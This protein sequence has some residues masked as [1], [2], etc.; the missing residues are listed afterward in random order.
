MSC[1]C[2]DREA[3]TTNVPWLPNRD[4]CG[5]GEK[6]REIAVRVRQQLQRAWSVGQY[7]ADAKA[8]CRLKQIRSMRSYFTAQ[9]SFIS[10][11]DI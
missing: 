7:H 2:V 9:F 5:V 6:S 11:W 1:V 4:Y 10:S 8:F 3:S